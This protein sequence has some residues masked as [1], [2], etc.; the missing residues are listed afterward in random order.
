MAQHPLADLIRNT[1]SVVIDGAMSTAL[2]KAGCDLNDKLWSA[3]VLIE[4]PE[5]IRQVHTD[6]F[7]AGANVAITASYQATEAGFKERGFDSAKAYELIARS[8]TLAKEARAE[9]LTRHPELDPKSLLLAGAV[10]PYGAY[11]ANGAE[12][13]G[14]Y[15]LADD[16]YR[17]FHQ[18]RMKA[19]VE[20]GADFLGIE[21]QARLDEVK[22]ILSMLED[23]D[24]SAWVTF[25]LKDSGHIADGT[26]IEEVF[27]VCGNHP[28]VDAVGINC[29]KREMV[30]EAL[31]RIASVT[32]K[33]MIVYPNSGE[34][35]DP[36][37]KSWHHPVSGP[38]WDNFVSKWKSMGAVCLGG[39]C[40]TLPSDIVQIAN[41]MKAAK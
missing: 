14:D 36:T 21:T 26:P 3:R 6:Y 1:G 40:R 12:Y 10:G 33:P 25:T 5:K 39:C 16:Q 17:A 24:A 15:H 18:L 31:E 19:L 30:A 8:V 11:L 27:A 37:T 28:L 2:E 9:F 20:A 38:G 22:V 29:I 32:D 23:L 13:T 4:Q 41:L 35:Y 34:T 7:E